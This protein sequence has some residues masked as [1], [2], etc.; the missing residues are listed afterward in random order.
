MRLPSSNWRA[1]KLFL[2]VIIALVFFFDPLL[3]AV[4]PPVLSKSSLVIRQNGTITFEF[5]G[6]AGDSRI[7]QVQ[8]AR[9]VGAK[10]VVNT[11]SV[12]TETVPGIFQAVVPLL[13]TESASFYRILASQPRPAKLLISEVMSDNSSV[14]PDANKDFWDWIEIHNPNDASVNLLGYSLTDDPIDLKKWTFPQVLLGPGGYLVVFASGLDWRV[15]AA[16]LHTNFKLSA[17]GESLILSGA[18][19]SIVNRLDLPP[20][21][22]DETY[23]LSPAGE[24]S[25]GVYS[26]NLATPGKLNA[27]LPMLQPIPPPQFSGD[28]QFLAAGSVLQ[29][30]IQSTLIGSTVRFT[31]NG[32]PVVPDSPRYVAPLI[33]TNTMMVRAKVFVGDRVSDESIRTFFFGVVH[34]LPVVSLAAAASNFEFKNGYLFGMGTN[35]LSS[36]GV[37]LQNYP[38]SG[39][40]AWQD[41]ETEVAIEFFESDRS[42]RFRQRVGMSVYGGWGSRGYPQKSLALF[43]RQKYGEGKMKHKF[44]A[45]RETDRF[46]SLVLRN[47]GNDNQSTHQTAPRPPIT[48]FGQTYSYGSYFVNGNFTL[49][50]D[51][52]EQRLLDVTD[53]DTQAYRPAVVYIN[54]EYWGIYNIREKIAEAYLLSNHGFERGEVDLIE[55]YGT[56]MAGDNLAY[57]AMRNFISTKDLKVAANYATVATQYLDI[58][59]FI[60]YHLAVIYFQNFDIGNIKCWRPRIGDGRFR[61]IVYDQ[62]YGF[63]LWPPNVYVPAMARDYA[64]YENMFKFYTAGTGTGT[65]WPNQGGRTLLLRKMLLND[66]FK[67]KFIQRCADLL[68]TQFEANHV[69]EVVHSMAA[70]IRSEIPRHLQRWSWAELLTRG[71]GPPYKSEFAPFTQAT[72]ESNIQQLVDFGR[73]RPN[74]LLR[75]CTNYFKLEKGFAQVATQILPSGAGRIQYNSA[76]ITNSSWSGTFFKDFPVAL[77]AIPRPG[78]QFVGWTSA[79]LTTNTP[80]WVLNL[81]EPTNSL[82]A[83]FEKVTLSSTNNPAIVLTEIHYHPGFEGE[84]GDWIELYN[85]G[86][87]AVQSSGWILRDDNDDTEF[88]L[89]ESSIPSKGFLVLCQNLLRFR[90][91]HPTITNCIGDFS[92]GL[93]NS[94]DTVRLYDPLGIPVLNLAYDDAAPWPVGADGTGYTLQLVDSRSYSTS[95]TAWRLSP[96]RGG[97][98]GQANP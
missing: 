81:T 18:D 24:G 85:P 88:V 23:G 91:L 61:W 90:R 84:S 19:G 74:K 45:D 6:D 72:W 13:Q 69:V 50:R 2:V 43:A 51:A 62:D 9:A 96:N 67:T 32:S 64:D 73:N 35:V 83:R 46:E 95:P 78:F 80:R 38:F 29:L 68:N 75:D 33:L 7:F 66:A 44:F 71:Y 65:G 41:R 70:G 93:D 21:G 98:P 30:G 28:I 40:N 12:L 34:D 47:S 55:A 77:A 16:G 37:V 15:A 42:S 63:N 39:S 87:S 20:L 5:Q 89:P 26:K 4:T 31:T 27:S 22:V 58:D 11:N 86:N 79:G 53:L 48:Q 92:F 1:K 60:D 17:S 59:N 10:W 8:I 76:I 36:T 52:M 25:Y 3:R 57:N 97:T 54:G 14:F 82:T 56:V 94:G 49:M